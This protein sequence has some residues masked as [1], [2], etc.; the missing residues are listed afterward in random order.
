MQNIN[1]TIDFYNIN[2]VTYFN[3]TVE[4][5]MS[6]AYKRFI[7]YMKPNGVIV[8]IGA[9]SGRDI[10]YFTEAGFKVHGIEASKE[11]CRLSTEYTGIFVKCQK[12]QDWNPNMQYDGVWANASLI[13]LQK[14]E[15]RDFINRL[16]NVLSEEGIIYISF[17]EDIEEGFDEKGR[18]F[19]GMK[20]KDILFLLSKG[21]KYSIIE[22]WI[23]EDALFRQ[24]VRWRNIICR[25]IESTN[26][27]N[28]TK[29]TYQMI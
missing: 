24:N 25:N 1:K 23:S 5:D 6:E 17:K 28:E 8:D 14:T 19:N 29:V 16:S 15:V 26:I 27:E 12:I 10:K 18:Y 13:H 11:L 3:N 2:A 21:G 4:A 20:I 9:G 22:N 7:K